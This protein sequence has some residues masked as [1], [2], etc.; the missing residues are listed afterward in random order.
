MEKRG[1]YFLGIL[2]VL[3]GLLGFLGS[4]VMVY[5]D[6][7]GTWTSGVTTD[8]VSALMAPRAGQQISLGLGLRLIHYFIGGLVILILG[9]GLLAMRR[10]VVPLIEEVTVTLKCPRPSCENEW[11]E[12]MAKTS[13]E[14]MGYPSVKSLA[15]RRCS[16]CGKFIRPRIIEVKGLKSNRK[17][18]EKSSK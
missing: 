3:L 5:L 14:S 2:F 17:E 18:N 13:L 10:R 4:L 11:E 8:I 12:S 16:K 15:R 1:S 7:I 6:S 9:G